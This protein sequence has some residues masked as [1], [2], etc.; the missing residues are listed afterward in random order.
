M[1]AVNFWKSQIGKK[2]VMAVTGLIGVGFVVGHMLGNLQM[3][4]GPEKMNAYAEFLHNLGGLLWLARAALLGAVILHVVA[5]VQ[6]TRQK[7]AARPVAYVKGTQW[8]VST[9]A[10]RSIR[11]GGALLLF[12]IVF[13]LAHFTWRVVYP[14]YSSTNIY[15]NVIAGF[16]KWYVS[17]FYLVTMAALF[18]HLYH[19][20]WSSPRTLGAVQPSRNPLARRVAPLIAIL[21]YLG[22]SA[23]PAAVLLGILK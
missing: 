6:L 16:S 18:L 1:W 8:E 4:Q 23:I 5:A 13:H 2:F 11:W 7:Q 22:F 21:V 10:S 17:L 9:F 12:F 3:F 19:G 15:G 20:V 14:G